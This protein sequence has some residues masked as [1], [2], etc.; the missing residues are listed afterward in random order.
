MAELCLI[1]QASS[2][3]VPASQSDIDILNSMPIGAFLEVT[4]TSK[5]NPRFHRKFF[6]LL[7]LG[8]DYWEPKSVSLSDAERTVIKQYNNFLIHYGGDRDAMENASEIFLARWE[9]KRSDRV[10]Q[11]V[12]SFDAYRRWATVEAGYFVER[13]MPDGSIIKEPVSIKFSKMDE[14]T[15]GELYKAVF[16]VLWRFILNRSFKSEQEAENTINQLM[17]YAA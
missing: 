17:G 5:R 13:V 3:L 11:I 7:N 9:K 16:S 12:K 6:S 8:F 1:K 10:V 14:T 15:F 4:A 2:V